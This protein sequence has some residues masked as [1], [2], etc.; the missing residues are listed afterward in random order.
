MIRVVSTLCVGLM[1]FTILTLYHISEQ[2]R[3]MRQDLAITQEQISTEQTQ[4]SVLEAQWQKVA[5]P[6][7]VQKLA[8]SQLGM[9]NTTTMQLASVTQLPRRGDEPLNGVEV[10]S[11]S[12]QLAQAPAHVVKAAVRSGM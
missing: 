2:T 10:H 12:A 9:Q 8:E 1:G 3:V 4:I 11:A 6:E 5:S 7:T